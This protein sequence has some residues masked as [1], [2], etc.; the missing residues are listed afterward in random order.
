MLAKADRNA[1]VISTAKAPKKANIVSNRA[2]GVL[3]ARPEYG[4]ASF[5][6]SKGVKAF[7]RLR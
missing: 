7:L 3:I 4:L 2:F 1:A 6:S 5:L